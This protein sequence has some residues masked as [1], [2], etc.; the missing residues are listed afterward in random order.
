MVQVNSSSLGYKNQHLVAPSHRRLGRGLV[1]QCL[2]KIIYFCTGCESDDDVGR[3]AF[4]FAV[5][6]SVR[7]QEFYVDRSMLFGTQE[8]VLFYLS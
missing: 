2:I 1:S 4:A 7:L 5:E 8:E 3:E 6:Q